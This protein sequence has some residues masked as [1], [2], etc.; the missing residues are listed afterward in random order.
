MEKGLNVK[1]TKII[2]D[3]VPKGREILESY[4]GLSGV[5]ESSHV[6]LNG[7]INYIKFNSVAILSQPFYSRELE[8]I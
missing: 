3:K 8:K 1:V 6:T 5:V 4:L 2:P 7:T